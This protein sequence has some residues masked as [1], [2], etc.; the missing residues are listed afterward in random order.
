MKMVKLK[1][2]QKL[3]VIKYNNIAFIALQ[4]NQTIF[5]LCNFPELYIKPSR[6]LI[7]L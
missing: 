6:S 4:N 1:S 7:T 5:K 2:S 3:V